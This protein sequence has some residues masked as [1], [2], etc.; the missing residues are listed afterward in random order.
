MRQRF[1]GS[2]FFYVQTLPLGRISS[3]PA[4]VGWEG[5]GGWGGPAQVHSMIIIRREYNQRFSVSSS[6]IG[7]RECITDDTLHVTL[8]PL[9]SHWISQATTSCYQ[10]QSNQFGKTKK[11]LALAIVKK[12]DVLAETVNIMW[13]AKQT[14]ATLGSYKQPMVPMWTHMQPLLLGS[15]L[16]CE[17][18]SQAV[19]VMRR[20]KKKNGSKSR[21]DWWWSKSSEM[22]INVDLQNNS[23]NKILS[24]IFWGFCSFHFI[25]QKF[26]FI[27]TNY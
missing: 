6:S 14:L 27:A 22:L 5:V 7:R 21:N 11:K 26:P 1:W 3:Q 15:D 25:K 18:V 24:M 10:K 9:V 16:L 8:K 13:R 4:G 19:T 17:V 2:S 20:G 23:W 12:P